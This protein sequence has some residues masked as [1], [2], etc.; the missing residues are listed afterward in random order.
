MPERIGRGEMQGADT[1]GVTRRIESFTVHDMPE[2]YGGSF[3]W[4][5]LSDGTREYSLDKNT[6]LETPEELDGWEKG[7]DALS[8]MGRLCDEDNTYTPAGVYDI[9]VTGDHIDIIHGL[10]WWD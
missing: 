2:H 6:V 1:A 8:W 7:D 9:T 4:Y 3:D 10:Y 5:S